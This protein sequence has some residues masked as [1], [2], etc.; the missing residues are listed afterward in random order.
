MMRTG[1]LGYTGCGAA[2][3][4]I[5]TTNATATPRCHARPDR[6]GLAVALE[7][8]AMCIPGWSGADPLLRICSAGRGGTRDDDAQNAVLARESR[9]TSIKFAWKVGKNCIAT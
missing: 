3:P 7:S 6:A 8:E 9:K 1:R 2:D 4:A 5:Q